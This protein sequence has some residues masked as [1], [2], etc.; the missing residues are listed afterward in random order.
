MRRQ[1]VGHLFN[2][3]SI[4][5]LAGNYPAFGVYCSTKFAVAGFTEALAVEMEPFSVHTTLVYPGYF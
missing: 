2:I 4:G 3:P 5:G 1:Q